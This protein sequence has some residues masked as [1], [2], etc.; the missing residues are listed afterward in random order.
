[1]SGKIGGRSLRFLHLRGTLTS[2]LN[3][4]IVFLLLLSLAGL[5]VWLRPTGREDK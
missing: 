2:K 1:M 3:V 5:V 4:V